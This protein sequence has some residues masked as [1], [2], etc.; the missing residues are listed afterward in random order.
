MPSIETTDS[1]AR[2]VL[3]DE[4]NDVFDQVDLV[5]EEHN[6]VQSYEDVVKRY[7][8]PETAQALTRVDLRS[9]QFGLRCE[10]SKVCLPGMEIDGL[11][12]A[13]GARGMSLILAV[14]TIM[15]L[16]VGARPAIELLRVLLSG[17]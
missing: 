4:L 8:T 15:A 17:F 11:H 2:R 3:G 6:E 5:E 9:E 13:I 12:I 14:L 16:L 10:I 1:L 7:L